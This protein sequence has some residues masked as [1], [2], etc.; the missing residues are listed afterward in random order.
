MTSM[1]HKILNIELQDST[2]NKE[3]KPK[4]RENGRRRDTK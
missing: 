4:S 1:T 3:K 2:K